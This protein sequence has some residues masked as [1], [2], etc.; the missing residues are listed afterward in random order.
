MLSRYANHDCC[1]QASCMSMA[2]TAPCSS[3]ILRGNGWWPLVPFDMIF[4]GLP[5]SPITLSWWPAQSVNSSSFT[6]Y[7]STH[8]NFMANL[9]VQSVDKSEG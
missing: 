7:I 4:R 6:G 8:S 1:N 5:E 3:S 2:S 9:D